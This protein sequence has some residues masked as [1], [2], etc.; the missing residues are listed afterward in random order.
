MSAH[1]GSFIIDEITYSAIIPSTSNLYFFR[2]SDNDEFILL[3]DPI[4]DIKKKNNSDF[5]VF[6]YPNTIINISLRESNVKE[7]RNI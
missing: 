5:T 3:F 6:Y 2:E 7:D 1:V 4:N